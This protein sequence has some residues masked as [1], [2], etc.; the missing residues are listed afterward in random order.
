MLDF[1]IHKISL[2]DSVWSALFASFYKI[3]SNASVFAEITRFFEFSRWPPTQYF[4]LEIAQFFR[5]TG[6]GGDASE[7]R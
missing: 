6:S 3:L 1:F 4:I 5:L 7:G 2:A